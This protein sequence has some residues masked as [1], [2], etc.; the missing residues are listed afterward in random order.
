MGVVADIE[1]KLD[2]HDTY[3]GS[4]VKTR[5]SKIYFN[6]QYLE[7]WRQMPPNSLNYKYEEKVHYNQT[8]RIFVNPPRQRRP[9]NQLY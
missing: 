3:S 2:N 6:L 4:I 5:R 8:C 9:I 1:S 7:W